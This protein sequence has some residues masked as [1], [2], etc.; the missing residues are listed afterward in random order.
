[1]V[2]PQP[3]VVDEASCQT[4]GWDGMRWKTLFSGDRTPTDQITQGIAEM[5]A[6]PPGALLLHRHPQTETYYVLSGTGVLQIDDQ[7]YPL[8]PGVAAF[9]P[10]GALHAA[11]ATGEEPLRI[12]YTFAA[13]SFSDVSYQF[14]DTLPSDHRSPG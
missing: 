10:G 4:D 6:P 5:R 7:Q 12:L 8:T 2:P 3:H 14:V 9:I 1:M 11:F 13:N